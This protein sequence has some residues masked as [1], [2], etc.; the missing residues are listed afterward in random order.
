MA[1]KI[2]VKRSA[3]PAKIPTTGDLDLGEIAI[4]TYDGKMYIKKNDGT[5]SIIE[6]GAGGGG[7]VNNVDG[8][9]ASSIYLISQNID[10]GDANG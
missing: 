1:N 3:V 7:G 6:I 2:Q 5:A 10:G 4:N 9:F 8:G